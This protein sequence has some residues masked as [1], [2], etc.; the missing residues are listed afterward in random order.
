MQIGDRIGIGTS[1]L[2]WII[3]RRVG[4]ARKSLAYGALREPVQNSVKRSQQFD[5]VRNP[6]FPG[7][8]RFTHPTVYE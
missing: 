1:W 8:V 2:P 4:G 5:S 3:H 7:V 6:P